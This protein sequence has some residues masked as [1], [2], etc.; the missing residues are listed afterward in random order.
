MHPVPLTMHSAVYV[1]RIVRGAICE[2]YRSIDFCFPQI[3]RGLGED[4]FLNEFSPHSSLAI[5]DV[6]NVFLL[7]IFL[8]RPSYSYLLFRVVATERLLIFSH[9]IYNIYISI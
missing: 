2:R 8:A 7:E 1:C 3:A 5:E 9:V 4:I 6:D